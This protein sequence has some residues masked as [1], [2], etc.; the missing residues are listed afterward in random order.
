MQK[1]YDTILLLEVSADLAAK[2]GESQTY[3]Y[4]CA[5]CGEEVRLAAASSTSMVPHF[6]HRSGNSDVECEYYLGQHGTLNT[7]ANSRRSK[8][9]RAEFYFDSNT[10]LFY[11]GL[12]FSEDEIS[13]YEQHST[14]FELRSS[15]QAQPFYS[16][17]ISRRNFVPDVQRLIPIERF[18]YNYFLSNTLIGTRRKYEVFNSSTSNAPT[19]FKVQVHDTR[20][21]AKLVRSTVIYTNVPYLIVFPNYTQHSS[22]VDVKLPSEIQVD[23][24]LRFTTMGMLFLGKVITI[25]SKTEQIDSLLSSWGYK[26]ESSETLTLLWPPAILAE[27]VFLIGTDMAY[28]YTTFELQ[29]HGNT[30]VHPDGVT[31]ISEEITEIAVKTKIKVYKK[32]TELTL[33][34]R[35]YVPSPCAKL[36]VS[37]KSVN[38]IQATDDSFFKFSRS[39]VHQLSVGEIAQ[40]TPGSTVNH[41]YRGYL[42]E[43][44]A[45]PKP[46]TIS[47]EKLL[48]DVLIH[49]K[50]TEPLSWDDFALIDLSQTAF[51]YI[52]SCEKTG[53]VNSAVKSLIKE[54]RI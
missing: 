27:D 38:E 49:Y 34:N 9:E 47:K 14:T 46:T 37:H 13:A 42:D 45:P 17:Q 3:R 35:K 48:Q 18:S 4:E 23:N 43:I 20:Y 33:E 41:Y 8:N 51:Q 31:K 16:I 40:L 22:L 26:L 6:R 11:L 10:K 2:A 53:A 25:A 24:T 50:R 21:R 15:S 32:N 1:A 54:G 39:G 29:P 19:L 52:K 44:V 28:L 5:N 12:R 7:D 30:N 36:T